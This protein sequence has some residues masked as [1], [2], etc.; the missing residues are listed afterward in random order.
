MLAAPSLGKCSRAHP[1]TR[2]ISNTDTMD[3][4]SSSVSSSG[5][6]SSDI[7]TGPTSPE[8]S[9]LLEPQIGLKN[10]GSRLAS[11]R[12]SRSAFD[13]NSLGPSALSDSDDAS[14]AV[15][16]VCVIGAGYVGKI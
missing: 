10:H 4:F 14:L 2:G 9:P 6:S 3:A 15:R 12:E 16:D 11:H 8:L 7:S 5:E 1:N 13:R